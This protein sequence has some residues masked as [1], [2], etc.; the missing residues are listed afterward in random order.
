[1][2]FFILGHCNRRREEARSS[3]AQRN[4]EQ[5]RRCSPNCTHIDPSVFFGGSSQTISDNRTRT[6]EISPSLTVDPSLP[7]KT[8]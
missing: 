8:H 6:N 7:S 4:L 1:M 5:R 3:A 2:F